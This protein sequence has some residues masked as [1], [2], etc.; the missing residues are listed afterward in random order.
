MAILAPGVVSRRVRRFLPRAGGSFSPLEGERGGKTSDAV[1]N[2]TRS[3]LKTHW[4]EAAARQQRNHKCKKNSRT[5][6]F[7]V[8]GWVG[9]SCAICLRAQ[10]SREVT[11]GASSEV[12]FSGLFSNANG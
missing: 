10:R 6:M 9:N 12:H 4:R 1:P 7:G 3:D 5:V 8:T 11:P 2:G